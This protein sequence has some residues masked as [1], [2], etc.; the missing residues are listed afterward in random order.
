MILLFAALTVCRQY[1]KGNPPQNGE[2]NVLPNLDLKWGFRSF[3]INPEITRE[4]CFIFLCLSERYLSNHWRDT[5]YDA[6]CETRV[7]NLIGVNFECKYAFEHVKTQKWI[8]FDKRSRRV[9]FLRYDVNL[10]LMRF[11][12]RLH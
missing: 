9:P 2:K 3:Q 1:N 6:V 8:Y 4:T 11:A 12:W 7:L 5:Y 10:R